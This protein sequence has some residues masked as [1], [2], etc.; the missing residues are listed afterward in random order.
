MQ[1]YTQPHTLT[2][3]DFVTAGD[4]LLKWMGTLWTAF[5]EDP[6]FARQYQRAKGIMAAQFTVW[7]QETAAL[8]DRRAI[9]V[10]HR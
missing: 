6:E 5:S 8:A 9:P 3:T 2:G 10:H 4:T 1:S 7:Y